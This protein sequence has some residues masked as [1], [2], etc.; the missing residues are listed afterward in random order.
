MWYFKKIY[1]FKNHTLKSLE[2]LPQLL[3]VIMEGGGQG[4]K[5]QGEYPSNFIY[6]G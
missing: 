4:I 2:E 6:F 3:T 5:R 1:V